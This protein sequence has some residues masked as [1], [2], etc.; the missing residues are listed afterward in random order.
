MR[1]RGSA[2]WVRKTKTPPDVQRCDGKRTGTT[3]AHG[4]GCDGTRY[5]TF[6]SRSRATS[7]DSTCLVNTWSFMPASFLS[8]IS[9]ILNL[10]AKSH[11]EGKSMERSVAVDPVLSSATAQSPPA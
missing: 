4:D 10:P 5:F 8:Q 11:I 3:A 9:R 7:W 2:A 1:R 6:V